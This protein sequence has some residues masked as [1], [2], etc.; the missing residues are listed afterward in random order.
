MLNYRV[1]KIKNKRTDKIVY[2]PAVTNTRRLDFNN[3]AEKVV[4]ETHLSLADITAG[5]TALVSVLKHNLLEGRRVRFGSLG[6]FFVTIRSKGGQAVKKEVGLK[7]ISHLR[8]RYLPSI[9]VKGGLK[10]GTLNFK[11]VE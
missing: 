1:R 9:K 3:L 4:R 7:D 5:V 6:S 2:F 11:K 10:L 8:I